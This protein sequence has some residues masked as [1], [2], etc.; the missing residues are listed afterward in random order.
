MKKFIFII[1]I[2][3]SIFIISGCDK[4]ESIYKKEGIYEVGEDIKPGEYILFSIDNNGR[5]LINT[6]KSV[7]ENERNKGISFSDNL[8][9]ELKSGDWIK[10]T[11]ANL[12]KIDDYEF[13]KY[14]TSGLKPGQYK[15]GQHITPGEYVVISEESKIEITTSPVNGEDYELRSFKCINRR[16]FELE[17]GQYI[18]FETGTIYKIEDAPEIKKSKDNSIISGQYKIGVDI[19]EG[20]YIITNEAKYQKTFHITWE[21]MEKTPGTVFEN[22]HYIDLEDGQYID[23][24]GKLY[25]ED[26]APELKRSLDRIY[27]PGQYLIGKDMSPGT[28]EFKPYVIYE[29]NKFCTISFVITTTPIAKIGSPSYITS[30]GPFINS[31]IY[32]LE[33]G[34]FIEIKS[35]HMKRK[36]N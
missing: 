20:R 23:F 34:Q 25:Q 26:E 19:E 15:V 7:V 5:Y 33:E 3:L 18:K 10:F 24:E 21:S 27:G 6:L 12:Y 32:T 9:I 4:D 31:V 1:F 29:T 36:I 16:Y 14:D 13:N 17:D 22:R 30:K 11:N 2:I 35:G 28:Y 8:F